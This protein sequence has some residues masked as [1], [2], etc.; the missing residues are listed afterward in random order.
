MASFDTV[1]FEEEVAD[2]SGDCAPVVGLFLQ[3]GTCTRCALLDSLWGT[4]VV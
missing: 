3:R 2:E 1:I 4:D